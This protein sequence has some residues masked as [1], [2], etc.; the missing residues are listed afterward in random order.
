[1]S[2]DKN[3]TPGCGFLI[4]A[5]GALMLLG[6]PVLALAIYALSPRLFGPHFFTRGTAFLATV[7][8][9]VLLAAILIIG[10][11]R[12]A[13]QVSIECPRPIVSA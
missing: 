7:T 5:S 9:C 13:S 4:L 2:E 1:M 10:E 12:P 6:L 3:K 11:A 8:A